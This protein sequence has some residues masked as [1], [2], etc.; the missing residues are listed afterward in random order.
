MTYRVTNTTMDRTKTHIHRR[1]PKLIMEPVVGGNRLGMGKSCEITDAQYEQTKAL[2]TE[3][4]SCGM[5]EIKKIGED[6]PK[7]EAKEKSFV[8][9]PETAKKLEFFEKTKVEDDLTT[10]ESAG[11]S[12]VKSE[13]PPSSESTPPKK[14]PG[15]P[16]KW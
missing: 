12:E 5:V 9:S 6:T 16:K 3:W 11:A 13:E 1:A 7:K 8:L 14:G 10:T 2:L 15:R 4:E